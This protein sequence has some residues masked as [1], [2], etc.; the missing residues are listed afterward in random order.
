MEGTEFEKVQRG[1]TR[2]VSGVVNKN[3]IKHIK[4]LI[5]EPFTMIINQSLNRGVFPDNLKIAKVKPL[6]KKR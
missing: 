2:F 4:H 6:I 3:S 1:S 5:S